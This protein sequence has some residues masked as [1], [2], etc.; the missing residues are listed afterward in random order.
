MRRLVE[1]HEKNDEW[2]KKQLSTQLGIGDNV[3]LS[4]INRVFSSAPFS[5]IF[6]YVIKLSD[7]LDGKP[8]ARMDDC[9]TQS[10]GFLFSDSNEEV[11]FA[12]SEIMDLS[13][14]SK[15]SFYQLFDMVVFL[16]AFILIYLLLIAVPEGRHRG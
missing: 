14:E 2:V 1:R 3:L 15:S 9:K 12:V 5:D 4:T 7:I 8:S 11:K 13:G 10:L 6:Q 16:A